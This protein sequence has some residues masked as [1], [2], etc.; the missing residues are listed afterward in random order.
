[1]SIE[2]LHVEHH[3]RDAPGPRVVIVH[4]S[5]DR[6][7]NFRFVIELLD[8]VP[9][10]IYDRRGYGQSLAAGAKGGGI[11]VHVRDLLELLG[12]TP[13]V[14]VGQSAGGATS[15]TAA[16]IAPELFLAVGAWEPPMTPYDFWPADVKAQTKLWAEDPDPFD[17]G[18]SFNRGML[19]DD[20]YD[21]LAEA[22]KAMLRDEGVAFRE[23]MRSQMSLYFEPQR[24]AVPSVI[25]C[26]ADE[27]RAPHTGMNQAT[28]S[29]LG[30]ELLYV[31]DAAHAAH[32]LQPAA[33]ARLVRATLELAAA[34]L[35][36]RPPS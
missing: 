14:V 20:R 21:A 9:I 18:E 26:G 23:D 31:P 5:P 27:R 6:S 12:E 8:D 2:D 25:G 30:S 4:G 36:G 15:I 3:H 10:T 32:I 13:S 34:P 28:A 24:L 7:R 11:P 16:T 17:L 29:M 35:A 22:T 1:M 19:G 33:W